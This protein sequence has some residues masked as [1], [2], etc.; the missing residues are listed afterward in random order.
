MATQ[1]KFITLEGRDGSGKTTQVKLL[2]EYLSRRGTDFICTWEPGGTRIGEH[3]RRILVDPELD[4]MTGPTEALLFA[5]SRAQ[6]VRQVIRPALD[7]GRHVISNR[8]VDSSLAY[9]AFGTG[10]D[11]ELVRT[12]NDIATDGLKPDLTILFDLEAGAE[13]ERM[14]DKHDRIERRGVEFMDRV[15]NGYLALARMEPD[16]FA[17]VQAGHEI[18]EIHARVVA[19]VDRVLGEERPRG[20]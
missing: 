16:R 19:L 4:E 8:Y 14:S 12:I 9:Q 5:A 15:R 7:A 10:L 20:R 2:C 17:V 6:L 3:I 13:P 11:L 1:G 18:H